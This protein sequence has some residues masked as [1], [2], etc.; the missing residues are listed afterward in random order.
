MSKKPEEKLIATSEFFS[1]SA[2]IYIAMLSV[3]LLV[4]YFFNENLLDALHVANRESFIELTVLGL[5]AGSVL[6]IASVLFEMEFA[7]YRLIKDYLL[8]VIGRAP[9]VT[10]VALSLLSAAG[11][12]VFFRVAMQPELGMV[13]TTL[14]FALL[15]LGPRGNP[16]SWT[17]MSA[18]ISLLLGVIFDYTESILPVFVAHS[19]MNLTSMFKLRVRYRKLLNELAQE[20]ETKA[21]DIPL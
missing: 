17:L 12:E 15:H 19:I 5:L 14:I 1:S 3:G 10:I 16:N 18:I 9:A 21:E 13:G 8:E 2:F 4:S 11:E 6:T 20:Q 7:E